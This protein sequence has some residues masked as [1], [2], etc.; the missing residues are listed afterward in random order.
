MKR[1]KNEIVSNIMLE[2]NYRLNLRTKSN[3]NKYNAPSKT[4]T[5]TKDEDHYESPEKQVRRSKPYSP[6][7]EGSQM[8]DLAHM[9]R[10]L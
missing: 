8:N 9:L 3:S 4:K 10:N 5:F 1:S 7:F 2:Q 6:N